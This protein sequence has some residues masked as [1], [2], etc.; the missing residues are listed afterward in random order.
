[1]GACPFGMLMS[2]TEIFMSCFRTVAWRLIAIGLLVWAPFA[3]AQS[4]LLDSFTVASSH[5]TTVGKWKSNPQQIQ[6]HMEYPREVRDR[7]P[8]ILYL[9][10]SS[11]FG[12]SDRSWIDLFLKSGYAV[13]WVD[14]Y[15]TRGRPVSS[16]LSQA[17]SEMTDMSFL[18]DVASG[19]RY[20]K[21][22]P[23]IDAT[24]IASFGR[25][26]GGTMAVYMADAW[27]AKAAMDGDVPSVRV[28]LFPGCHLSTREPK[29]TAGKTFFFLG[30]DDN[31][32]HPKPCVDFMN[33]L[34]K[35]GAHAEVKIYP[36]AQHSFDS[37]VQYRVRRPGW[38]HCHGVWDPDTWVLENRL[39]G[40]SHNMKDGS[41]GQVFTVCSGMV[42]VSGY[43]T[44]TSRRLAEQDVMQVLSEHL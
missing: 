17:Q 16:G 39:D 14:Q 2:L 43:G 6:A 25:S 30:E 35:A 33:R 22:Q 3:S 44:D 27:Y 19:F 13:L 5:P 38:G 21:T 42:N 34:S 41:W 31:F 26:W 10:S 1:M 32:T 40:T 15:T 29:P 11:G 4:V 8:A 9:L 20:L 18:H 24:R 28:A 37:V 36:K 7:Y 12:S 23:R